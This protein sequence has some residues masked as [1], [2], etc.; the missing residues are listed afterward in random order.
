MGSIPD[1]EVGR[2]IGRGV[3]RRRERGRKEWHRLIVLLFRR[4]RQTN[5]R[6]KANLGTKPKA[7]TGSKRLYLKIKI[8]KRHG[9]CLACIRL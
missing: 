1:T 7:S 9:T 4:M 5:H 3:W 6:F 8:R 2:G